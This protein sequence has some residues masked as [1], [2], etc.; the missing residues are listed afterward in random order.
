MINFNNWDNLKHRECAWYLNIFT[1]STFNIFKIVKEGNQLFG[2]A[3]KHKFDFS[4]YISFFFKNGDFNEIV[5][6]DYEGEFDFYYLLNLGEE[7]NVSIENINEIS[8]DFFYY[9]GKEYK[10]VK[11]KYNN[12]YQNIYDY[13][14]YY[15]LKVNL[16]SILHD[17]I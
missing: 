10:M 6:F 16:K 15:H 7:L 9:L 17:N 4:S 5:S 2:Y 12:N 11:Y 1:L 8:N 3:G 13:D 14:I